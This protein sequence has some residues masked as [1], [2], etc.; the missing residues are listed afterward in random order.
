MIAKAHCQ[1]ETNCP[2]PTVN[3]PTITRNGWTIVGWNTNSGSTTANIQ[4]NGTITLTKDT[5]YYAI[6]TKT[7]TGTFNKGNGIYKFNGSTSNTST[8]KTCTIANT[9]EKCS[10]DSPSIT[11][12]TG[13]YAPDWT[14]LPIQLTAN[15]TTT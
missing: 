9:S 4:T 7:I 10:I 5:T 2:N 11:C 8:T 3:A 1:S 6:T 15:I 13:Y 12:S 14:K